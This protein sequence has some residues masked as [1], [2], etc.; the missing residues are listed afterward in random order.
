M[1][2]VTLHNLAADARTAADSFAR[3]E[4]PALTAPELQALLESFC[5]IDAV[6]NAVAA[7][8]IRI[9]VRNE[10]YVICTGE[11]HLMLYDAAHRELP[12][13]VLTVGGVMAE[14][15]GSAQAARNTS[16]HEH[17][18]AAA[19]Q[20]SAAPVPRASRP[21]LLTLGA[22]AGALLGAIIA[23]RMG[24]RT[25]VIPGTFHALKSA[26]VA[27]LEPALVG[28][29][30]TGNQPG[31]HGLVF[32][33]AD[34]LKLFELTARSA[35]QMVGASGE[36]GRIGPRL[37]LATNQPGGLIEITGKDT[38]VYCGEVYRRIP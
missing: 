28:V 6:E 17:Q 11:K 12:A 34:E 8:E 7:P 31:Q 16:V 5:E 10:R 4:F 9:K 36:W 35:P 37:V 3:I 33:R 26:E 13:L 38:L 32:N 24:S 23:L 29:Y 27:E 30:L 1:Y 18:L 20:E 14:L 2:D 25:V 21:R 22:T 19:E 15:D